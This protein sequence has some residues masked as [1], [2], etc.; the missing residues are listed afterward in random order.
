MVLISLAYGLR[1][2]IRSNPFRNVIASTMSQ[3]RSY[4][5]LRTDQQVPTTMFVFWLISS[6]FSQLHRSLRNSVPER[7]MV[8]P[9]VGTLSFGKSVLAVGILITTFVPIPILWTLRPGNDGLNAGLT[10]LCLLMALTFFIGHLVEIYY[11]RERRRGTRSTD[12]VLTVQ[13]PERSKYW[14]VWVCFLETL[15]IPCWILRVMLL[16]S[17]IVVCASEAV[18]IL[19]SSLHSNRHP[20]S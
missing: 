5:N 4:G 13:Q 17:S 16:T 11:P 9:W 18:F 6:L 7:F 15:T 19:V 12:E 10:G 2:L 1:L 3:A 8:R 14:V 20:L